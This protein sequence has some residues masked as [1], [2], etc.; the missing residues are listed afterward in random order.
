MNIIYSDDLGDYVVINIDYL[1]D[2]QDLAH[3]KMFGNR[4][5]GGVTFFYKDL[6]TMGE[7]RARIGSS[8]P[9]VAIYIKDTNDFYMFHSDTKTMC[10]KVN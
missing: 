6:S 7:I 9:L 3:I 8:E 1:F 5:I 2:K 4:I 10:H